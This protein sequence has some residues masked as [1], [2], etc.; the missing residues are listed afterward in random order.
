ML[1]TL[2]QNY[3]VTP[4]PPPPVGRD[5]DVSDVLHDEFAWRRHEAFQKD[6]YEQKRKPRKKKPSTAPTKDA[7]AI[8][9]APVS[10]SLD[11]P[12]ES[13]GASHDSSTQALAQ[14]TSGTVIAAAD[15]PP[16]RAGLESAASVKT[17][18]ANP[19]LDEQ[20]RLA[21]IAVLLLDD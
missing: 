14:A 11:Q 4:P 2:L 18:G 21:A 15:S 20:L 16:V 17:T 7:P 1:L 3:G 9:L 8:P 10:S 5:G 13:S 12:A 6:K 19:A